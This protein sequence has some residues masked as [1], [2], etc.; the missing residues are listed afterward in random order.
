LTI[1]IVRTLEALDDADATAPWQ[2]EIAR[3]AEFLLRHQRE[4]GLWGN[5]VHDPDSRHDTSGSAGLAAAL[6][7]ASRRGWL[8][9]E[10]LEA[11]R[12]TREGLVAQL[13]PDGL[14]GGAAQSNKGGDGLQTGSYRVLYQMGMGLMAQLVAALEG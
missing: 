2:E 7:R 8:G 4:D 14:L 5:F 9:E 3:V 1:G 12:R 13:T 11:A 10:A 6:A